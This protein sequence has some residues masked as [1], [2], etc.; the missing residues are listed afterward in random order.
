MSRRKKNGIFISK[1]DYELFCYCTKLVAYEHPTSIIRLLRNPFRTVAV[2]EWQYRKMIKSISVQNEKLFIEGYY[3]NECVNCNEY[4]MGLVDAIIDTNGEFTVN[5][6]SY[7]QSLSV[8]CKNLGIPFS[9]S[10][11]F[12]LSDKLNSDSVFFK[13]D[14][15]NDFNENG[16]I[17]NENGI[18]EDI[19]F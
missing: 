1:Y 5:R 17:F 16:I 13:H 14:Y 3:D 2:L 11:G 12:I 8:I 7:E 10:A 4:I 19:P 9:S 15:T 6:I 18:D